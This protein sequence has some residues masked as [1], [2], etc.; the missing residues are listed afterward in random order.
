MSPGGAASPGRDAPFVYEGYELDPERAELRCTYSLG[1]DRFVERVTFDPGGRWDDPRVDPAA[2]WVFLLSAVSYYKTAAPTV[3]ELGDLALTASEREFLRSFYVDGLGEFAYRNDIDLDRLD[4]RGPREPAPAA[5]APVEPGRATGSGAPGEPGRATGSGTPVA[6]RPLVPF[7][8]GI[9]SIVSAELVGRRFPDAA[10]FVVSAAGTRFEA[11]E[12]PAALTGLGVR[13]AERALD[14]QLLDP[15]RPGYL[16]GHVP[17]TGII[18]A[19]AVLAAVLFDH[20][21]VVMSNEW[22][23]SIG[24]LT[25]GDRRINHQYSKGL[26]FEAGFR[27]V[28]GATVGPRP[29][30][31]SLLRPYSEVWVARRF[32]RLDRYH[33]AF[34]SCNRA[35]HLDPARRLDRWCGE[36]D[37][38]CFIDLVLA[39]YLTPGAL[40]AI[41]GGVEPLERPG[42]AERFRTL[43][44]T[45][46]APK[47]F[48]CVGDVGECRTALLLAAARADRAGSR[49]V[50]ALAAE[51]AAAGGAPAPADHERPRG[52][53]W[54]PDAYAAQDQLV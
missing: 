2:R 36:C 42:L 13:R 31:F 22:S 20:D 7:G 50:Q 21:A 29:Q 12:R 19:L 33:D 26:E 15:G 32:A 45:S 39:P 17:V 11:I 1:A 44:G 51:V 24:S 34:R 6:G 18:S 30:Y 8:G 4:L 54:V 37:K 28:L 25:D 23:A 40:G 46:A 9:D 10:L 53:H 43:L 38:C 48:E 3:I 27:A 16:N 49:L 14:R 47:P 41:F 35:F 52:D 5:L